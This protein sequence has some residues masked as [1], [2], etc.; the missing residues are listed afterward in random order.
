MHLGEIYCFWGNLISGSML[1]QL[2]NSGTKVVHPGPWGTHCFWGNLIS[3]K[4]IVQW[5]SLWCLTDHFIGQAQSP[6]RCSLPSMV[7]TEFVKSLDTFFMNVS[8]W[9][10]AQMC[11]QAPNPS[12]I[13]IFLKM[14]F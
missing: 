13:G 3:A 14:G 8:A 2:S 6:W 9:A 12:D 5:R 4:L 7:R 1:Y 11:N 10:T